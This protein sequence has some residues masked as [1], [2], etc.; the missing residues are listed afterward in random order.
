[1]ALA[2]VSSLATKPSLVEWVNRKGRK[3]S[4]L[5]MDAPKAHN[6]PIYLKECKK[7]NVVRMVR[8]C[9][10]TYPADEVERAGIAMSEMEYDDGMAPPPEIIRS[11]LDVVDATFRSGGPSANDS[12]HAGG[13]GGGA[14]EG[15]TPTVAV[16]C[17]AGLGRAP[18]LV[19]IALI[20]NGMESSEA[21][22]YIRARRRGA[23]NRKQLSYLE[24]YQRIR[25]KGGS[26]ETE[27]IW[28]VV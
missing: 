4:F 6:L 26:L 17:V 10:K 2:Q 16:H 1:M 12:M 23:I 20:E 15:G 28:T 11:W 27:R 24:Q 5:I 3:L 18:V 8:V 7:H 14:G 22:E 13:G 19:A 25:H 9:E 21:V